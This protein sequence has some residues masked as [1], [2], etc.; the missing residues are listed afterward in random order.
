M[1]LACDL[2]VA[3]PIHH[4][5]RTRYIQT[6]AKM[7]VTWYQGSQYDTAVDTLE[8]RISKLLNQ[9]IFILQL[10]SS[11]WASERD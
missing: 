8:L 9:S 5:V 2:P 6:C 3:L 7:S 11:F 10:F 1:M 4:A